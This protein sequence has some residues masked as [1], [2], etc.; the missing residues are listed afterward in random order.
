[1][2]IN[3][4]DTTLGV[5]LLHI[6]FN[7]FLF[8]VSFPT[9]SARTFTNIVFSI[10]FLS[11]IKHITDLLTCFF[12]LWQLYG[13]IYS[14]PNSAS[15]HLLILCGSGSATKLILCPVLWP[16]LWPILFHCFF[17]QL[18]SHH[19]S[20]AI[21]ILGLRKAFYWQRIP[22]S[23]CARKQTVDRDI[24]VTSRNGDRKTL[25]SIRITS[26]PILRKG[27]WNQLIQLRWICTKVVPI[28][29]T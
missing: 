8:S 2:S 7:L 3:N 24:L 1:M 4:T 5:P 29:K 19:C 14:S 11:T 13:G 28:D 21:Q 16:I 26:R 20:K 25:Q 22:E 18:C 10:F 27:K 6:F 12:H 9:R 23:S 17:F 15:L